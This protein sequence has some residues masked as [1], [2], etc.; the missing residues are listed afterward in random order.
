MLWRVRRNPGLQREQPEDESDLDRAGQWDVD[1]RSHAGL[2]LLRVP[3]D[4]S[5]RPAYATLDHA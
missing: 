3:V 5:A 4:R 1:G 2:R